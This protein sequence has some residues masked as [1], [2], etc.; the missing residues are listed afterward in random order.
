MPKENTYNIASLCSVADLLMGQSPPGETYN[1]E[2]KGYPL[3]NGPTEFGLDHPIPCLWTTAPTKICEKG[4]LL[5]C[6]RG[7]TTGRMNWADQAYC[8]GRGLCAIR[9]KTGFL[10]TNYI[11]YSLIYELSRLLSLCSGSVFLNLSRNDLEE[12]EIR[13]SPNSQE[14][15][16]NTSILMYIENKIKLN[17]ETNKT[18]EAVGGAVF[19]R[20]FVDFE[21]PNQESKPYKSSGGKMIDSD[22][23]LIPNEWKHD[24]MS[25]LFTVTDG[26]HDSPKKTEPGYYLIT[27]KHVKEQEIDFSQAYKISETDFI[28][29]NRRSRVN[30]N[31]ILVTMIGT[32]GNILLV[33]ENT[34][35]FAIKNIGLFKSS[36]RPDLF[37]YIF[38]YLKSSKS[39]DYV[40]TRTSGT[41]QGYLTLESIRDFPVLI[42]SV[43]L[44]SN[45]KKIVNPLLEKIWLNRN[46]TKTLQ[47]VR[48]ALLPKLMSG[49][50]R[51]PI[52]K[53]EMETTDNA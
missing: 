37:E 42:P 8:I 23:G 24:K 15:A 1:K 20:W 47:N 29:I 36:E 28:E 19:K 39:K 9:A 41:T 4:D 5:F 21:F 49:K 30:T 34:I 27:S 48:T 38:Y 11:Y 25:S 45:F 16:K 18:L 10:D 53:E 46:Q 2:G 22:M 32:V 35:D 12:F 7:T 13:W 3:L 50:I 31:D 51:V 44:I 40:R 6:V 17:Q 43:D 33:Q 52:R 14:R 26:T